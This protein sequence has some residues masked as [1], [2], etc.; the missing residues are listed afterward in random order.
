MRCDVEKIVDQRD[1]GCFVVTKGSIPKVGFEPF[2]SRII[3]GGQNY[4]LRD[5]GASGSHAVRE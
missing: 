3:F 1:S 5:I 2:H 4:L